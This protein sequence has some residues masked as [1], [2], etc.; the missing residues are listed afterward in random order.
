MLRHGPFFNPQ[1]RQAEEDDGRD[2]RGREKASS[3]GHYA[4]PANWPIA[5]K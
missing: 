4:I 3:A 5:A 1:G 2:R